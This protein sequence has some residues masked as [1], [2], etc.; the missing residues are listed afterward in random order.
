MN[1]ELQNAFEYKDDRD[2]DSASMAVSVSRPRADE[3]EEAI[4]RRLRK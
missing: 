2:D 3:K 1:V 4:Q